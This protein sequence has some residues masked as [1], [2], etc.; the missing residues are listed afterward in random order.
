[1]L[2]ISEEA[3]RC[4]DSFSES[5]NRNTN[6]CHINFWGGTLKTGFYSCQAQRRLKDIRVS[7][8]RIGCGVTFLRLSC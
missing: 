1:M 3:K 8:I 6:H 4:E 7:Q 2:G 5:N